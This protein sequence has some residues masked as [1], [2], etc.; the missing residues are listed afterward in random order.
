MWK[1]QVQS[2]NEVRQTEGL[3]SAQRW[4]PQIDGARLE[5]PL[6]EPQRL[7]SGKSWQNHDNAALTCE[8]APRCAA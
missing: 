2:A 6:P 7:L 3:N 1:L 8:K 4:N 5:G